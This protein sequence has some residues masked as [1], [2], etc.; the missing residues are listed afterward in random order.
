MSKRRMFTQNRF[1]VVLRDPKCQDTSTIVGMSLERGTSMSGTQT[2]DIGT[3]TNSTTCSR[4]CLA[5]EGCNQWSFFTE[6]R[7]KMACG[8]KNAYKI[9]RSSVFDSGEK[10][11]FEGNIPIM[12]FI[13]P[14]VRTFLPYRVRI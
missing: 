2:R 14:C 3:A 5:T 10:I 13:L 11:C 7:E 1:L 9:K 12:I 4:N 8:Q 6:G